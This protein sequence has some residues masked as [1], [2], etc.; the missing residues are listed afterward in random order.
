MRLILVSIILCAAVV[1][2]KSADDYAD[3]PTSI[4]CM[5]FLDDTPMNFNHD[6]RVKA[7]EDRVGNAAEACK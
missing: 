4:L 1:G 3:T 6:S 2:C 5:D 7:L